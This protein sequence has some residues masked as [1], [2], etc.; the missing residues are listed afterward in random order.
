MTC[1][2][3]SWVS[4]EMFSVKEASSMKVVSFSI[5]VFSPNLLL[6]IMFLVPFVEIMVVGEIL[7]LTE[8]VLLSLDE[9]YY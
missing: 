5:K 3:V 7:A 8:R 4:S 9:Y 2:K 1:Q 6:S